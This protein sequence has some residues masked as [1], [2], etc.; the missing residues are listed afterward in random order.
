MIHR[1]F[2]TSV[3]CIVASCRSTPR[4]VDLPP[5]YEREGIEVSVTEVLRTTTKDKGVAGSA[6]NHSGREVS[7][8][9]EFRA[10]DAYGADI[11][12]ARAEKGSWK[13]GERWQFRATYDRANVEDVKTILPGKVR[14]GPPR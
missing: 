11:A 12:K 14:L 8:Q 9:L 10:L 1:A 5:L 7:C 13:P 6:W 4:G 3:V 2:L